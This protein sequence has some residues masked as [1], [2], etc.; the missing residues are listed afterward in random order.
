MREAASFTK[1]Q[2]VGFSLVTLVLGSVL[3]LVLAELVVRQLDKS[4]VNKGAPRN[5]EHAE[6]G[7]L[8]Q[9]GR[10]GTHTT[11][12]FAARYTIN[13]LS[14]NDDS[15]AQGSSPEQAILVVGDSHTF[16]IGASVDEVWPHVLET[17]LFKS[18]EEGVVYNAAVIGHS[19]GQYLLRIRG[20]E[21]AIEPDVILIGFSMAT[22]LYDLIPPERGGFVYGGDADRVYFDL[23]A[24]GGL[25]EKV[26]ATRA[27]APEVEEAVEREPPAAQRSSLRELMMRSALVQR[28]KRSKLAMWIATHWRPGDQALW[29]GLDTALKI[30]LNEDDAY[31][32][33]LAAKL[34]HQIAEEA[35]A[36]GIE[37]ALVN[38]PYLAQVYD[39]VWQASF[40]SAPDKYD[41]GIAGRRLEEICDEAGIH[42]IDATPAF[43]ERARETGRWL[44]HPY[45]AHPTPEGHALIAEVVADGLA[46]RGI[47]SSDQERIPSSAP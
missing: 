23:D 40:G 4:R 1:S 41:R 3:A 46:A 31:R 24:D 45:D 10:R 5:I 21:G 2:I 14:M 34:L 20:L 17:T 8:P 33:A 11:E 44:H 12:E 18:A 9:P 16:A 22:D 37:V 28:F 47:I 29:P 32:W 15:L 25:V 19:L 43:I 7:W 6:L 42:Y 26:K 38:I 30:E 13:A 39:D 27:D 35:H 36:K